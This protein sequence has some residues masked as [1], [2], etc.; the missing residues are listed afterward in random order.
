MIG[1]TGHDLSLIDSFL[2]NDSVYSRPSLSSILNS[3]STS[4]STDNSGNSQSNK[5][6]ILDSSS[7]NIDIKGRT[8]DAL[9]SVSETLTE[10]QQRAD[11]Q[12]AHLNGLKAQS[13]IDDFNLP[14][15]AGIF[16]ALFSISYFP[17]D[18]LLA[19]TLICCGSVGSMFA[20]QRAGNVNTIRQL[21]FGVVAGFIAFL[22][23]K[24]GRY[25]FLIGTSSDTLSVNPYASA[26]IG[27]VAG[28]FTERIYVVFERVFAVL[29]ETFEGR[30]RNSQLDSGKSETK[31][32][33]A[34][35]FQAAG[36]AP[37]SK[38]AN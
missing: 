32:S 18:I 5:K 7:V 28:L 38:P 13:K 11:E 33:P 30:V 26:F 10:F 2:I 37:Q 9:T 1:I 3:Y 21:F 14:I 34:D 17:N 19:V 23:I 27:I 29:M 20:A 31:V 6:S 12:Q 8:Q 16:P 15:W 4:S 36:A 35:T 25:L 24:G 22:S